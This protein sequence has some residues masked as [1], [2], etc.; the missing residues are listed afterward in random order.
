MPK[1]D[2]GAAVI[3]AGVVGISVARA[4]AARTPTLLL[5]RLPA[6]ATLT[7]ARNSGIVHAGL[8]HPPNSLKTRLCLRGAALLQTFCETRDIPFHR[9][10]K[11][12]VAQ[13]Q[14]EAAFLHNLHAHASALA[15][16]TQFLTRGRLLMLEPDICAGEAVL[17][18]P[19]TAIVDTSAL[20]AALLADVQ[21]HSADIAFGSTVT[22]IRR[23]DVGSG[24][25]LD[26]SCGDLPSISISAD[27]VVNAAGH[28]S[29]RLANLTSLEKFTPHYCKGTYFAYSG[30]ARPKHLIYP[31]PNKDL[32]GLGIHLTLDTA[33]QIRF[34]PDTEWARHLFGLR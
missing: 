16:P 24:W 17:L 6:P 21:T 4:L 32:A 27:C 8:Y 10:G 34:G 30:P 31:C 26:V 7:S 14:P 15:V 29:C 13:S 25:I 33:G 19:N 23:A 20:I 3:G 28:D 1:L 5:E 22:G 11:L 2:F 12:V 9:V 18:S